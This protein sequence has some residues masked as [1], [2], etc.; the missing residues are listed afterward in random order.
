[1][2]SCSKSEDVTSQAGTTGATAVKAAF[3]VQFPTATNVSWNNVQDFEVAKFMLT[4]TTKS[5]ASGSHSCAAWYSGNGKW[6]MTEVDYTFEQ[7]S[8]TVKKAF[9]ASDYG[10]GT[11][12]IVKVV[13]LT[14]NDGTDF[15]KIEVS[16]SGVNS[17]LLYFKADGTLAKDKELKSDYSD[18]DNYPTAAPAEIQAY[19]T[20]TYP[21]AVVKDVMKGKWGYW[22][23]IQDGTVYRNLFFSITYQLVFAVSDGTLTDTPQA[24]QDAFKASSYA[25]WTVKHVESF[26]MTGV[27][28]VV[29]IIK[30]V[31][32]KKR[33]TL[34]YKADGS[35]LQEQSCK[36]PF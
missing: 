14:K 26:Q 32:N 15:F 23:E 2:M 18:C 25:T 17:H 30:V 27:T 34:I 31:Q 13:K 24:V 33:A 22:V 3:A 10:D 4:S 1:M 36:Y 9:T 7:L 20:A 21:S 16:K 12:S 19:I 5:T 11:W 35:L 8:D 28:D 6:Q 29:Y